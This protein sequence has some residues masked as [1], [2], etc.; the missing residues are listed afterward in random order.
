[1]ILL[2][3]TG[4]ASQDYF[5]IETSYGRMVLR[6]YDET[7]LHRDNFGKLGDEGCY[8]DTTFH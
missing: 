2:T 5:E 3:M 4:C 7:P 8:C 6:V 1:M